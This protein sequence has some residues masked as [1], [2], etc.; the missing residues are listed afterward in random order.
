[1]TETPM[2]AVVDCSLPLDQQVVQ[3]V[4]LTAEEIAERE[5]RAAEA[6]AAEAE[7]VAQEEAKA[8]KKAAVIAAL[9]EAAGLD[10]DDVTAALNA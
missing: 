2:N 8:V 5:S 4:P 1:M 3:I 9:A 7:R 10:I 6:A